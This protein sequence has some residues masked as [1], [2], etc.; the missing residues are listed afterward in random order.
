VNGTKAVFIGY[1]VLIVIGLVY[2][3]ALGMAHQ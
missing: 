2:F 3:T 1:L